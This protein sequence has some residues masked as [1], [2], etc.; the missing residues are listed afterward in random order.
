MHTD[1][2]MENKMQGRGDRPA[3]CKRHA[4]HVPACVHS[5]CLYATLPAG[6][7]NSQ[8]FD[9]PLVGRS[10]QG[11]PSWCICKLAVI[12][13]PSDAYR[14]SSMLTKIWLMVGASKGVCPLNIQYSSTPTAHM[15]TS[16]AQPAGQDERPFSIFRCPVNHPRLFRGERQRQSAIQKLNT[17]K[18]HNELHCGGQTV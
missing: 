9:V 8:M 3:A 15:S 1:A 14:P 16:P 17:G 13:A 2:Y 12:Q 7:Q 18:M 4:S 11:F 10:A 6:G 5:V